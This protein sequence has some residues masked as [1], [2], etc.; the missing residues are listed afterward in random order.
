[1]RY[2]ATKS[3]LRQPITIISAVIAV[4]TYLIAIIRHVEPA[5]SLILS[6]Q[7]VLIGLLLELQVEVLKNRDANSESWEF[8]RK[9]RESPEFFS[10]VEKIISAWSDSQA[11]NVPFS[12]L[13]RLIA[14]KFDQFS[15]DVVDLA[16]G[17][18]QFDAD[19]WFSI[20][21]LMMSAAKREILAVSHA[22]SHS[23]WDTPTGRLYWQTNR[24]R[25]SKGVKCKRIFVLSQRDLADPSR[26][27]NVVRI[28]RDQAAAG[29]TILVAE[30]TSLPPRLCRDMAIVDRSTRSFLLWTGTGT[31]VG[32]ELAWN[33]HLVHSAVS[34]FDLLAE[35]SIGL[36]SYLARRVAIERGDVLSN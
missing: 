28:M 4:A 27:N 19:Q 24:E 17:R 9:M 25:I 1:M 8:N 23:I 35:K 2:K 6:I 10:F 31:S 5:M 11:E 12:G 22:E 13:R 33:P 21:T 15:T 3:F 30:E 26:F 16:G 18:A 29:A 14:S 36:E 20:D 7:P 32:I 34:S